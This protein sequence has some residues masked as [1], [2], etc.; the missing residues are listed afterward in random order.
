MFGKELCDE[1]GAPLVDVVTRPC[2]CCCCPGPCDFDSLGPG[3]QSQSPYQTQTQP[4]PRCLGRMYVLSAT[5]AVVDSRGLRKRNQYGPDDLTYDKYPELRELVPRSHSIVCAVE[6]GSV[7]VVGT[8]KGMQKFT[9]LNVSE[10]DDSTGPNQQTSNQMCDRNKIKAATHFLVTNKANGKAAVISAFYSEP[11]PSEEQLSDSVSTLPQ[12]KRGGSLFFILGSKNVH[13]VVKADK[14]HTLETEIPEKLSLVRGIASVIKSHLLQVNKDPEKWQNLIDLL[15]E[16]TLCGEYEDGEHIVPREGPPDIS[17]FAVVPKQGSCSL[18]RYSVFSHLR[19]LGL[20]TVQ[21]SLYPM[22]ELQQQLVK[23]RTTPHIEGAVIDFLCSS[24]ATCGTTPISNSYKLLEIV[25]FK[26][27]WYVLTR[28]VREL[29]KNLFSPHRM[30]FSTYSK[31]QIVEEVMSRISQTLAVRSTDFLHLSNETLDSYNALYHKFVTWFVDKGLT[32]YDLT[33]GMA[34]HWSNFLKETGTNDV[35]AEAQIDETKI[36]GDLNSTSNSAAPAPC[37]LL[38]LTHGIPADGKSVRSKYICHELNKRGYSAVVIEQ[39]HYSGDRTQTVRAFSELCSDYSNRVVILSRCNSCPQQYN[40][41][42]DIAKSEGMNILG[43][44]PSDVTSIQ[45]VLVSIGSIITRQ[46]HPTMTEKD[47]ESLATYIMAMLSFH[48][49]F[50]IPTIGADVDFLHSFRLLTEYEAEPSIIQ[51]LESYSQRVKEN[52]FNCEPV[53]LE[54]IL[55][56]LKSTDFNHLRLPLEEVCPPLVNVITKILDTTPPNL[57]QPLF[58]AVFVP[59]DIRLQLKQLCLQHSTNIVDTSAMTWYG[60]HL[61]LIHRRQSNSQPE[62]WHQAMHHMAN[63]TP[64]TVTIT[65]LVVDPSAGAVAATVEVSID[66]R[67]ASY[68]VASGIPHITGFLCNTK[69]PMEM[70][71]IVRKAAPNTRINLDT[72][73]LQWT[74]HIAASQC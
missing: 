24:P 30:A 27:V 1:R 18:D 5:A 4:R 32:G 28:S 42:K 43:L 50:Q 59:S 67:D 25:K 74:T 3:L 66:G 46:N 29:L 20:P 65:G 49:T 51:F 17:W 41:Y 31:E 21:F 26:S 19:N 14:L 2:G 61:T 22:P 64:A 15:I 35:I 52:P 34:R 11:C 33:N 47:P 62:V 58:L 56:V 12:A 37:R 55:S 45:Q 60:E 53:S 10:E 16:N 73:C 72:K 40:T 7:R 69:K 38:V 39:D 70:V 63:R 23:L 71:E 13:V 48:A 8:L 54:E 57:P 44:A 9:G 68:L 36:L 6:K